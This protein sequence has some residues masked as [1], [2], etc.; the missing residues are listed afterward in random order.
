[1][2][3]FTCVFEDLP[4]YSVMEKMLAPYSDK[5]SITRQF[6]CYGNGKIRKQINAYNMASLHAPFFVITDLDTT[7]CAPS[8][9]EDW[10]TEAQNPLMLFRVA[11]REIE[12]WIMADKNNFAAFMAVKRDLLP[13]NPDNLADPKNELL[14]IAKKSRN[15][16]IREAFVPID[17]TAKTGP[18]YNERLMYFVENHWDIQKAKQ[19]SPSLNKA[20]IALEKYMERNHA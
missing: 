8:L 11:V 13:A 4:T 6:N 10:F 18:L 16:N 9:I 3:Y 19:Y 2:L 14:S 7:E 20:W 15:R 17:E 5:C 1:M 12:S